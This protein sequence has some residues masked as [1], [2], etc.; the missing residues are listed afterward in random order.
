VLYLLH[1]LA[2]HSAA[3]FAALA[4]GA[5]YFAVLGTHAGSRQASQWHASVASELGLP[6][7]Y[8]LD[9]VVAAFDDAGFD[10]SVARLEMRFV[11]VSD[12]RGGGHEHRSGMA[13]WLDYYTRDKVVFRFTRPMT[14]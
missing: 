2:P 5:P 14:A 11:P 10:V 7:L 4:P 8:D 12:R 1:D 13:D 6:P 3:M 9:D